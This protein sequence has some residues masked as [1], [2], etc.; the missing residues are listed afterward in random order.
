[1]DSIAGPTQAAFDTY[2]F[3]DIALSKD[4]AY[5]TPKAGATEKKGCK[6]TIACTVATPGAVSVS[7]DLCTTTAGAESLWVMTGSL[8]NSY[9]NPKFTFTSRD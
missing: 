8:T 7:Y 5:F 2:I 4:V 6:V 3:S 1:M 9:L